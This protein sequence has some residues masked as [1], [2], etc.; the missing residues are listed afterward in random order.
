MIPI[1]ALLCGIRYHHPPRRVN[2]YVNLLKHGHLDYSFD[3]GM[4]LRSLR[5]K[6]LHSTL[7]QYKNQTEK[8]WRS[9]SK[10]ASVFQLINTYIKFIVT[11]YT[12]KYNQV[13]SHKEINKMS[14]DI[15]L[16][17]RRMNNNPHR[18]I[19]ILHTA[20]TTTTTCNISIANFIYSQKCASLCITMCSIVLVHLSLT[21]IIEVLW[22][23]YIY[24]YQIS[25][26]PTL[27]FKY[28]IN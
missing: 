9:W 24:A 21:C 11:Y 18:L 7:D 1:A 13:A 15:A 5:S 25:H 20:M 23:L 3:S 12:H 26:E 27:I 19:F 22:T 6:K 4:L 28:S 2:N 14:L 8:C 10:V 17:V 16:C